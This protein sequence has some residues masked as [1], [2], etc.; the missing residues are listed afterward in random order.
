MTK[1]LYRVTKR[2]ANGSSKTHVAEVHADLD[3]T[4]RRA[5][6]HHI[7]AE[8]GTV[9]KIRPTESRRRQPGEAALKKYKE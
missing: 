2:A 9:H 4:A 3:E 7:F 6:V 8:G 1:F 5:I